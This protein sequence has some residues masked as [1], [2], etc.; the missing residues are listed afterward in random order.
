MGMDYVPGKSLQ[1][2]MKERFS[3]G[4]KFSDSEAAALMRGILQ[5]VNYIHEKSIVHRDL[6]P[7]NILVMD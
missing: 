5:G 2:Y 6:K 1:N 4:E 3:R 7:Q